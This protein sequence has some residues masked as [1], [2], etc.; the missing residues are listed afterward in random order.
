MKV[1]LTCGVE[2]NMR[3]RKPEHVHKPGVCFSV[4]CIEAFEWSSPSDDDRKSASS[5]SSESETAE[6]REQERSADDA[7]KIDKI[8]TNWSSKEW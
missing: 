8:L 7:M 4:D 3:K 6:L 1:K 2:V 5:S